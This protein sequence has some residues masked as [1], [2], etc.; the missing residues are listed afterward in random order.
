MPAKAENTEAKLNLYQK[1]NLIK[2]EF[3]ALEK[4]GHNAFHGY[5]YITAG[6]VMHRLRDLCVLHGVFI[7]ASCKT[8]THEALPKEGLLTSIMMEYTIVDVDD[9]AAVPIV[10][11]VPGSGADK[12]DKGIY[13]ALTGNYKYFATGMFQL[14]TDD[15]PENDGKI[16]QQPRSNTSTRPTAPGAVVVA[17]KV[18]GGVYHQ[19]AGVVIYDTKLAGKITNDEFTAANAAFK[20]GGHRFD[21]A[22]KHWKGGRYLGPQYDRYLVAGKPEAPQQQPLSGGPAPVA[23]NVEAYD[24]GATGFEDFENDELP[25]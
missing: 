12:G 17:S 19:P 7:S 3:G 21:S 2:K 15:D 4:D 25:F 24:A 23:D 5:K 11:Q 13:K 14:S 8:V 18:A 6:Q 22:A 1:L 20:S 9:L 10:V 16:A